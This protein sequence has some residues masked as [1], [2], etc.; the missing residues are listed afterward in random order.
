MTLVSYPEILFLLGLLKLVLKVE[1]LELFFFAQHFIKKLALEVL[2]VLPQL[3]ELILILS[4][5][6]LLGHFKHPDE[7]VLLVFQAHLV[8]LHNFLQ[9]R[10]SQL[11]LSLQL[12]PILLS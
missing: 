1:L 10:V 8:L 7:V 9:L 11:Q 5:D 4:L 2:H 3:L 12:L 6:F